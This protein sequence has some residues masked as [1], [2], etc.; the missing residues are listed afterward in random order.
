MAL[1]V[2]VRPLLR[3]HV[4]SEHSVRLIYDRVVNSDPLWERLAVDGIELICPHRKVGKPPLQDVRLQLLKKKSGRRRAGR[5]QLR[6]SDSSPDFM[7][8]GESSS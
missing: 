6:T 1:N 2:L 8:A 3:R 4:L 5:N 7:W